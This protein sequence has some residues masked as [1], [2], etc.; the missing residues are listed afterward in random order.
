VFS[1]H[2]LNL[3]K[4]KK[5]GG[6]TTKVEIFKGRDL[7]PPFVATL[8]VEVPAIT[9]TIE[10]DKKISLT[11]LVFIVLEIARILLKHILEEIN[12]MLVEEYCGKR[13][14]RGKE[15]RNGYRKRTIVTLLG[16]VTLNLR[17][18][19]GKGIPLYDLIEFE[20]RRKYQSDVKAISV[21]SA[22]RMTYRDA[23]DEINRF[24]S[25]P[26]HQTIWRYTQELG[27]K[28]GREFKANIYF[29][30]DSTKLHSWNGKM[31]LTIFEGENVVVR[32]GREERIGMEKELNLI[33]LGDAD[34]KLKVKERQI[35]LIHVWRE[36]NYKLWQHNVDLK[37]R[38]K[39]VNEVKGIL[40]RLKNSI[41]ELTEEK[42]EE[43]EK[44]LN[45]F[46][47]EM[48][49]NGFWRVSR[50]FRKHMKSILLFAYKKLE[51]MSIPWHNNRMERKM[52]EISKRM[53]NKW[54]KWSDRGAEN[55]ASLLMKMRFEKDVYESFIV[56]VMKLDK[57]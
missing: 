24:T 9:L 30:E 26:S 29:A 44:A 4:L 37:T 7:T 8:K 23:R 3:N 51:G 55:L 31:E 52:G 40:L 47:E 45:E 56:E 27:E 11:T 5:I 36:V 53:K 57:D 54:M 10:Y 38:K 34:K 17:R 25:S 49:S 20:Q 21:D 22:L 48:D 2:E 32:V 19:R 14:E 15:Y 18:I 50:F 43:V 46:V 6:V 42:I 28:I 12:E 16:E 41:D 39:Y 1:Y 13:Y 33:A 35:D